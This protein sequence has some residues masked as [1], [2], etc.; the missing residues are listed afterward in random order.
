VL[1]IDATPTIELSDKSKII[2]AGFDPKT[3][4]RKGKQPRK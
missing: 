3:A 4:F 2:K 1:G